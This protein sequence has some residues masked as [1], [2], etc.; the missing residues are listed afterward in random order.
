MKTLREMIDLLESIQESSESKDNLISMLNSFG[1]YPSDDK[2][3]WKRDMIVYVND[4]TGDEILRSGMHWEHRD[5]ASGNSA[6]DLADYL[7]KQQ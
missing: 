2:S 7:S 5:G 6:E 3:D 4:E 1:Y